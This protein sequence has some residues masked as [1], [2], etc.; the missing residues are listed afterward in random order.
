[1][2]T[3]EHRAILEGNKGTRTPLGDPHKGLRE[4]G[5]LAVT[6]KYGEK[7]EERNEEEGGGREFN[8]KVEKY[9]PTSHQKDF[10]HLPRINSRVA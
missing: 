1:M 8:F 2:G 6:K 7:I 4:E 3:W 10:V 5:E 9:I